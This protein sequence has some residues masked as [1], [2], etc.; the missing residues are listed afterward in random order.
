MAALGGTLVGSKAQ[1]GWSPQCQARQAEQS[2]GRG[3][4]QRAGCWSPGEDRGCWEH[5]KATNGNMGL[6]SGLRVTWGEEATGVE[7][8]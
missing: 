8:H 4:R 5:A 6:C 1:K 7:L 3:D 2:M